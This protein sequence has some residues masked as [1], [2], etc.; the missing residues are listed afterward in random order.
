MRVTKRT[1]WECADCSDDSM[2]IENEF[3]GPYMTASINVYESDE[4][5]SFTLDVETAIELRDHLNVMLEG[6]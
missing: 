1:S 2:T 6:L 4:K 3:T 5:C